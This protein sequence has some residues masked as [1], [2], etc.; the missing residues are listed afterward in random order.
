MFNKIREFGK[1]TKRSLCNMGEKILKQNAEVEKAKYEMIGNITTDVIDK[2]SNGVKKIFDSKEC[3]LVV[4]LTAIGV[5]AGLVAS[6]YIKT[7]V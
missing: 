4:G 3:R 6:V 2:T 7:P 5:G 1:K